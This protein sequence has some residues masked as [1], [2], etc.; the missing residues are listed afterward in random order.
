MVEVARAITA[1]RDLRAVL[2]QIVAQACLLLGA[3]R[4]A[5]A[6]LEQG[7]GD[8]PRIRFVAAR[9]LSDDFTRL[10]PLNRRDGTTATAIFERRPTWSADILNDAALALTPSTRGFVEAEGYRA[11]LSVPLLAGERTLGAVVLYRDRPGPFSDEEIDLLQVFAAHASVALENAELYHRAET[12]AQKLSALSSLTQRITSAGSSHQVFAAVAEAA[13]RL[14]DACAARVWVDDRDAAGLRAEATFSPDAALAVQLGEVTAMPYGGG[15]VPSIF[16]SRTAQYVRDVRDDPRWRDVALASAAGLHACA[17]VPLLSGDDVVGVLA[18]LFTERRDF[19]AEDRELLELLAGQAAIAI[20]QVQAYAEAERRRREAEVVAELTRG[21]SAS[22]ELDIV[23]ERVARGGQDLCGA[24]AA[25]IALRAPGEAVL[26]FRHAHG[27]RSEHW[28]ELRIE[29][30]KG[31]GGR[32]LVTGAPVR[33]GDYFADP[34]ISRDYAEATTAEGGVAQMVVPIHGQEGVEGLLYVLNRSA[35]RFT[36]RDEAILTRLA[37]YASTAIRNAALYQALQ[38]AHEESARSQAELVKS[39]RLRALGEMAA[40]VAHD[41]NN[42][43]AVILGRSELMLRRL[44]EPT[45]AAWAETIRRAARDGAD[46]VR[47]IQEFTRTRTTR[48]FDRVALRPV[49]REVVELT[50][51]RWED[52]AQSRGAHFEVRVDAPADAAV[53]GRPEELREVFTN[54][55][56]NALDAMPG[57]G[58]CVLALATRDD[59]VEVEVADTG[60]GMTDEVR[61][62]IFEPFFTTKGPRGTGLGLAVVWGIVTRHG[63]SI[64]VASSPG[65]GSR[66]TV[67]LPLAGE[68]TTVEP[69]PPPASASRVGRI[70]VVDDEPEVRS[71]LAAILEEGGH[72]V[73]EAASGAE[74]LARCAREPF[75]IVLSDLSM[76]R[77]SG[78]ELAAACRE[79][80]PAMPVALVTGWGD[81]LDPA[82]LERH[83]VRFVVAKPFEAA[84]VLQQV[85]G[86]F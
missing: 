14:L 8:E 76:P 84:R 56:V 77:M 30:G 34:E 19:T 81:Q 18:V 57:G 38:R 52:E 25:A 44:S 60:S 31:L 22:L 32:V 73:A 68:I 27:M 48:T 63:G 13:A 4:L 12:R 86:I 35:R 67:R 11:V 69:P 10:R 51:P 79:R 37:Q 72:A 49:L 26:R 17:G 58:S 3:D 62:R 1:S 70:L 45:L 39:E 21:I 9:G 7:A 65:Q 54:L 71:V 20:R 15:L 41:F 5:L 43:L 24:D 36:D 2:D 40:G 53:A 28:R 78:W 83:Q 66:F 85:A 47:R 74:A 23:L 33:T 82:Q 46:T 61:R 29:P 42:L 75:D 55:V 16:A 50:R 59:V 6:V 64:R 80:F